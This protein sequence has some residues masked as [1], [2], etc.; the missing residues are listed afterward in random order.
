MRNITF[1]TS[2]LNPFKLQYFEN[3]GR[4]YKIR[5]LFTKESDKDCN[6]NYLNVKSLYCEINKLKNEKNYDNP[7]CFD[8]I[9]K[10]GDDIIIF[11][12]YGPLTNLIGIF[13]LKIKRKK[14]FV[15]VDGWKRNVR[16]HKLRKLI[17]Y[18][19]FKGDF[20]FLCSGETTKENLISYKVNESRIFIYPMTS[21]SESDIIN[22]PL[23]FFE[24]QKIKE[25]LGINATKVVIT[26]G[27]FIKSKRIEDLIIAKKNISQDILLV[28]IGGKCTPEYESIIKNNGIENIM[29]V[30]FIDSDKLFDY[31]KCSDVFVMPSES[32]VWGL[33]VNEAMANGL[34]I[35]V[36]KNVIAGLELIVDNEN[37]FLFDVGD[38]K[39]ISKYIQ[40]ILCDENLANKI[41]LNN[42]KKI[43]DYTYEN[44][45]I[46]IERIL[47]E[48]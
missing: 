9:K 26:V 12:G 23:N 25:K 31:Y 13:Y 21:I 16:E 18:L 47:E 36:S 34:P 4:R 11:D 42:L 3:L 7:I 44:A 33:V 45:A 22:K 5:I 20:T 38:I 35:I 14:F 15:F 30:D 10:L 41:S 17:K 1:I 46:E 29:F 32:D 6:D 19:V 27:R 8:L 48:N 28:I 39:S 24:K 40:K 43:R 37:G 2:S